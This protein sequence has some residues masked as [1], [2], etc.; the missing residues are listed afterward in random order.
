MERFQTG[1]C[2]TFAEDKQKIVFSCFYFSE[3]DHGYDVIIFDVDSKDTSVGMRA[4]HKHL[5]KEHC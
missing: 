2:A 3:S 1:F 5:S 4:H